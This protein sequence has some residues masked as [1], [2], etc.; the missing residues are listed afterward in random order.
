MKTAAIAIIVCFALT[1]SPAA[2]GEA[3]ELELSDGSVI[4]G[5]VLS[6]AKGIYTIKSESLGTIRIE[7]SKIR[8]IRSRVASAAPLSAASLSG[9]VGTSADVKT[10][11]SKM[12]GDQDVMNL[13]HSL[14]NDPEFK[15]ILEDPEIMHAVQTGDVAALL[16]KPKFLELLNNPTVH[17]IEKKV[18]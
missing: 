4:T 6:L 18:N 3:R 8:A 7:E 11:Q 16:G 10:L 1:G 12:A 5:E 2:A 13:I 15:E 14:Q 9:A 17:Q